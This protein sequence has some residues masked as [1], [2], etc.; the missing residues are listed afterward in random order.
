MSGIILDQNI[1]RINFSGTASAFAFKQTGN[2]INIY[3]ASGSIL[4][5]TAPVQGDA[6]GTIIGFSNGNASA[7]LSGGVMKLGGV[8]VSSAAAAVIVPVLTN[9]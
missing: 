7:V 4:I 3:N 1:E 2:K 6:D 8:T 5:A 9:P